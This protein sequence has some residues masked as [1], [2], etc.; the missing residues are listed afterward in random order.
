MKV[1]LNGIKKD[2][3]ETVKT[4]PDLLAF[5]NKKPEHM[6]IEHNTVLVKGADCKN[7]INENDVIEIIHFM[8]GG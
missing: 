5:L 2:L 8:G 4:I 3:P 1:S 7:T 6:M